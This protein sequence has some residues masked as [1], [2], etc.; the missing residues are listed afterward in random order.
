MDDPITVTKFKDPTSRAVMQKMQLPSL[1]RGLTCYT[2]TP[3][4][5]GIV[6]LTGGLNMRPSPWEWSAECHAQDANTGIWQQLPSLNVARSG[7]ASSA[8]GTSIYVVAGWNGK[9]YM[10]TIEFLD[11]AESELDWKIFMVTALSPRQLPS[12]SP[13]SDTQLLIMGGDY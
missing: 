5:G 10:E 2:V 9:N 8:L 6:V 1:N 12:F 3:A 13:I 4:I 7:H 11:M